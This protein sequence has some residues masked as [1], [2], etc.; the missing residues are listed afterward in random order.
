LLYFLKKNYVRDR[1]FRFA[2][3]SK[4]VGFAVF[5][6]KRVI[7]PHFDVYFHLW[8]DGVRIG[9]QSLESGRRKRMPPGS[10]S[11]DVRILNKSP[12][13]VI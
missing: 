6:L 9:I 7:T 12:L 2:V 1:H 13:L 8:R 10:L 5:D 11:L 3:A 4:A